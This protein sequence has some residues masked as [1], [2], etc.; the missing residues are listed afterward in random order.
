MK[1]I[2]PP[3]HPADA[4]HTFDWK[5]YKADFEPVVEVFQDH[6]GSGEQPNAPGV[7]NRPHHNAWIVPQLLSGD[8]FGLIASGDHQGISC[9]AVLTRELTREALYE[10]FKARLTFGTSGFAMKLL[11]SCNGHPMGSSLDTETGNFRLTAEA[12]DPIKEIQVLRDGIVESV[13]PVGAATADKT[14]TGQR[15]RSGEFWFCRVMMQNGHI[16]WTSPIWL[17]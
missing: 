8:R 14:W 16:A 4:G 10:A 6:R 13:I 15:K 5:T 12:G 17:G 3:H 9:A 1:L 7:A 11:L 2:A